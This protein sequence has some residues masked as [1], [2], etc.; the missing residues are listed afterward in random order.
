MSLTPRVDVLPAENRLGPFIPIGLPKLPELRTE[1]GWILLHAWLNDCNHRHGK[2][3]LD[4]VSLQTDM[5]VPKR[6]LDVGVNVDE[7]QSRLVETKTLRQRDDIKYI[8]LS[9]PWGKN[10]V[11]RPHFVSNIDNIS[12]RKTRI[13]DDDLPATLRDAVVTTRH[14]GVRY[15]WVDAICILQATKSHPG[16]FSDEA[17]FM[18][19]IF[20]SAYCVL[21]ASSAEDMHS[22]FLQVGKHLARKERRAVQAHSAESNGTVFICD[23]SDDFQRDVVD[24]PLSKRGWVF[25]ERALARRTIFFTDNQIY[26]ECS[27]GFRCESM[28]KLIK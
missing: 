14:L 23:T 9:H 17:A 3:Q 27:D 6:L 12:Q 8:A 24:G 2:K 16:D 10:T 11:D 15:L 19:Y 22:G 1:A 20:S 18:E 13:L 5:Y 7:S 21:A 4:C 28:S 26:W 25:Q